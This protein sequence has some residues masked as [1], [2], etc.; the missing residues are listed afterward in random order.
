MGLTSRH[1]YLHLP[2]QFQYL[3]GRHRIHK[4]AHRLGSLG[5]RRNCQ[6]RQIALSSPRGCRASENCGHGFSSVRATVP[7]VEYC[8][9]SVKDLGLA[10]TRTGERG[11]VKL[12]GYFSAPNY[13]HLAECH[14]VKN[15]SSYVQDTQVLRTM[16]SMA[17]TSRGWL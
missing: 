17:D 11:E 9:G 6:K 15:Y 1:G 14:T 16:V 12:S 10:L 4:V 8:C 13:E 7:C 2:G 3:P 5:L